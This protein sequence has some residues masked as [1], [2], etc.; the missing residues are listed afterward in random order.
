MRLELAFPPEW[1]R[2]EA[3]PATVYTAPGGVTFEVFPI[4]ARTAVTVDDLL[5]HGVP[6]GAAVERAPVEN[7]ATKTG[8]PIRIHQV[9]LPGEVRVVA[10]YELLV[11]AGMVVVRAPAVELLEN[12]RATIRELL[13]TASPHLA[14]D[15]PAAI[16][17]LWEM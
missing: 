3:P 12:N 7:H 5:L 16:S 1:A 4:V 13:A 9:A 17:E 11:Y 2:A 14:G 10:H 15:T 6:A 8:W